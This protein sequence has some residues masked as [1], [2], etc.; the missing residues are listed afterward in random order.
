M[1]KT[2]TA[3]FALT[4]SIAGMNGLSAQYDYN[5][6][7]GQRFSYGYEEQS[8]AKSEEL[9]RTLMTERAA[10]KSV[11]IMVQAIEAIQKDLKEGTLD[12]E[13]TNTILGLVQEIRELTTQD[14]SAKSEIPTSGSS[15]HTPNK[16]YKY[17]PDYH[18][19]YQIPC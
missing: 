12:E 18:Y 6:D 14:T 8:R 7:Y 16:C 9:M 19:N 17:D 2:I 1:K 3:L 5:Y 13:T 10:E 4:L 15:E 11:T